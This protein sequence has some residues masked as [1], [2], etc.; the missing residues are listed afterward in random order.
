MLPE[1]EME[2]LELKRARFFNIQ[3]AKAFFTIRAFVFAA[4]LAQRIDPPQQRQRQH[5]NDLPPEP[6]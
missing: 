1:H 3:H 2:F 4:T 5:R 6:T